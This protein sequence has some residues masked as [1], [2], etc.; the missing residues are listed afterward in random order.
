MIKRPVIIFPI[1]FLA[2]G[3]SAQQ[4][5]QYSQWSFNQFA[6]NPAHAG[7]K[8]C[9]DIHSLYR[10]QWVGFQ[11]APKSGFLSFCVPLRAK[12]NEYLSARH[13]LGMRFENDRIGQFNSI[14]FNVA[15][16]GHFNFTRDTRLSLGL[17]GGILQMGYNPQGSI[18]IQPD[19][20]LH[21]EASFITPD[22]SFGAWWN[23]K[24]YYIGTVLQNLIRYKW[25]N[26]GTNSFLR[27][28]LLINGGY[29]MRINE[30]VSFIPAFLLKIPPHAPWSIDLQ[31]NMDIK[32]MFD[33]G[34]GYRNNDAITFFW[35]YKFNH[36]L[37]IIYSFDL[38]TST[39]RNYSSNTHELSLSFNSCRKDKTTSVS[40]PLF[41]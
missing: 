18:T 5:A 12:R 13:G 1:L 17:S 38:T 31:V 25:N 34:V 9:M 29:R 19:P 22:A 26:P 8:S 32:N 28:V 27:T 4:V 23:S 39:I 11:G 41:E 14:R 33:I 40:C 10:S 7:I 2:C 20:Q 3:L 30:S 37:S 15:Y 24:D 21:R 16:A 36:K 35:G 6:I